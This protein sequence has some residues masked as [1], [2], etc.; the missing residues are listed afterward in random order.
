MVLLIDNYDSFVYNLMRYVQELGFTTQVH[1]NDRLTIS[2]I[3]SLQ[4]SHI[5]LSPGPGTPQTAG[6][7]LNAIQYFA[8]SIPILGVCLGHQAIGQAF[9]AEVIAAKQPTHGKAS[10]IQHDEKGIFQ[11]LGNPLKVGRYHSL[12]V[13]PDGLPECLEVTAF[14]ADGE[15]MALQHR[16]H[17]TI[18]L[19]FHPESILTEQGHALLFNFLRHLP[20]KRGIGNCFAQKLESCLNPV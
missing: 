10:F 5:V 18:G 4:P 9:G 11:G 17:P 6:I 7:C 1:R 19:Q 8:P 13:S 15:I 14:T 3:E 2:Q 16:S 12:A 20:S